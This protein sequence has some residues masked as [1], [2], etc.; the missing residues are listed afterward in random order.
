MSR[1]LKILL[2]GFG[3]I[4]TRLT[5]QLSPEQ[6]DVVGARRRPPEDSGVTVLAADACDVSQVTDLLRIG[7][8]AVVVTMTPSQRSEQGYRDSYLRSIETL[9]AA[10]KKTGAQPFVLWVSSTGVYGQN[11]GELVDEQSPTEPANFSGQVLLQ[12][13]RL[14][15]SSDL[16]NC[17]VRFS[18]IYGPGRQAMLRAV[19]EDKPLT[20]PFGWT[21]RI[22]SEDCVGVL[23]HLLDLY[24]RGEPLAQVYLASDDEPVMQ[25]QLRAYLKE[26]LGVESEP[27]NRVTIEETGKRCSNRLLKESG[28]GLR[29]PDYR[30][31]YTHE[32]NNQQEN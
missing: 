30:S 32:V 15:Q 8:D 21:N 27:F 16:P 25:W 1:R 26:L 29:Y 9:L 6:Y 4:A 5:R 2:L 17:I 10:S 23:A 18:G 11:S 14:L 7:F 28:Y 3:D 13:E 22:H 12:A 31:G 24:R 19:K 20:S